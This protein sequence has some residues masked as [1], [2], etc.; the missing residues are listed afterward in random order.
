MLENTFRMN[1]PWDLTG[2]PAVSVPFGW[3]ADNLPI[4][5]Q[6]VGRHFDEAT[7]LRVAAA[8]EE[9]GGALATHPPV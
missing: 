4:G 7:V 1:V 6:L 3:S 9:L 2:S 8:L 5:L